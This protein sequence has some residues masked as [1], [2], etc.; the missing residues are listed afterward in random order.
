[1]ITK[2]N[3]NMTQYTLDV[4]DKWKKI[5]SSGDTI[6]MQNC[7]NTTAYLQIVDEEPTEDIDWGHMLYGRTDQPF[8]ATHD[9]FARTMDR[10]VIIVVQKD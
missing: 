7:S 9:I 2:N 3:G 4:T 6:N 10:T 5:A 8:V 1:M